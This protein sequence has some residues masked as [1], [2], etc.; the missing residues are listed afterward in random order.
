MWPHTLENKLSIEGRGIAWWKRK[1][2]IAY[3]PIRM[4]IS[5]PDIR[6]VLYV[7]VQ[8]SMDSDKEVYIYYP[9]N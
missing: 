8:M 4:I 7:A 9:R 3:G 5:I 1:L 6:K 2:S